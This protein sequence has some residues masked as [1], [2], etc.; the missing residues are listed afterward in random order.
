MNIL[1]LVEYNIWAHRLIGKQI[2]SMPSALFVKDHGGSFGS[3]KAT[4]IHLLESDWLWIKR[5]N[6]IPLADLPA[7]HFEEAADV[8]KEWKPVQ[9]EMLKFAARE[10]GNLTQKIS[11]IT[12]KGVPYESPL[13]D[14]LVHI[15]N[16]GTYHRGQLTHMIRVAGLQPVSTDYFLYC[17]QTGSSRL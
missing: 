9:D 16:H 14:L 13:E 7:W 6:G 4:I 15:T 5:F 10:A 8:Y 11:F 3:V 1:K 12:R 17:A 2:E